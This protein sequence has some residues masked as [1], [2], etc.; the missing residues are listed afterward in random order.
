[1]VFHFFFLLTVLWST[2]YK[3]KSGTKNTFAIITMVLSLECI[4][5]LPLL[6]TETL[7]SFPN[8]NSFNYDSFL[9]HM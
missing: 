3:K 6:M 4:L 2:N 7:D 1:M 9:P 8:T 5:I